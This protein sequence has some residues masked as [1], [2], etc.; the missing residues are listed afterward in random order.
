MKHR[1]HAPGVGFEVCAADL[2]GQ[3]MA[4]ATTWVATGFIAVWTPHQQ[5]RHF[6]AQHRQRRHRKLSSLTK[7]T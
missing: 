5:H 6:P 4:V 7:L 3:R 2:I 1:V